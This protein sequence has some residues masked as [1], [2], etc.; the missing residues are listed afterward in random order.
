MTKQMKYFIIA[1]AL[2]ACAVA[3]PIADSSDASHHWF[4]FGKFVQKHG[5]SY[6]SV[7]EFSAR[8]ATFKNWAEYIA[9]HNAKA[10]KTYELAINKFADH[11]WDEFRSMC[12]VKTRGRPAVLAVGA[13]IDAVFT[14][15][16]PWIPLS[17]PRPFVQPPRPLPRR[18][19]RRLA[20]KGL[21]QQRQG[22]GL[23]QLLR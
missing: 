17:E 12:V 10:D 11:T 14:L 13:G 6:S 9:N 4:E 7:E 18:H 1:A 2:V 5:K 21:R 8:F 22:P 20:R 15:Q 3:I 19:R 16:V 23:Q